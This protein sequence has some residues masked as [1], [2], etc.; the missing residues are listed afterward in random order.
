VTSI[1]RLVLVPKLDRLWK[2]LNNVGFDSYDLDV[3][4]SSSWDHRKRIGRY[5]VSRLILIGAH[6]RQA[7]EDSAEKGV[8]FN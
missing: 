4:V 1:E 5:T 6:D 7:D 3:R 2:E 8:S